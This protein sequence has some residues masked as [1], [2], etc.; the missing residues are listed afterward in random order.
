[1]SQQSVDGGS[2]SLVGV[3]GGYLFICYRDVSLTRLI[4]SCITGGLVVVCFTREVCFTGG[5]Y[6]ELMRGLF[7]MMWSIIRVGPACVRV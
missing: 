5:F 7:G 1:M 2:P 6:T 4:W 3:A